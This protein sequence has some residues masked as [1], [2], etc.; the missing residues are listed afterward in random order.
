VYVA[1]VIA[2]RFE[3]CVSLSFPPFIVL[4]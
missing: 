4:V 2:L 3:G 1:Y